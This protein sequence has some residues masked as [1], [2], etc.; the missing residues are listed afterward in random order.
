[1]LSSGAVVFYNRCN[2][3]LANSI[4]SAT[5]GDTYDWFSVDLSGFGRNPVPL[6]TRPDL[7]DT[8]TNADAEDCLDGT[9]STITLATAGAPY[10][11]DVDQDGTSESYEAQLNAD[12]QTNEVIWSAAAKYFFRKGAT[13]T[14]DGVQ[15]Q[16]FRFLDAAYTVTK[17]SPIGT[18]AGGTIFYARGWVPVD[19]DVV[20]AS[21]YQ[22]VTSDGVPKKPPTFRL[23]A[24]TGLSSG[25]KVLLTR[26]SSPGFALTAEFTL[27]SGNDSGDGTLVIAE[28]IPADKPP[29]GFVRVFD[30]TGQEDR[31]AYSSWSGSTF[32]LTGTLSKTYA[33]GNDSYVPYIDE[34]ASSA[35]ISKSLRYVSDRDVVLFV[36][37]G[38]GAGK[39][40]PFV[41]NF[42]L[43]DSDSSVPA[44]V[45]ADSINSN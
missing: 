29:S 30:N 16:L 2:R 21:T 42:T 23:R 9:T 40:I 35:S 14:F 10:S 39:M 7:D 12:G 41:S 33:A 31:Y 20:D 1:M 18:I 26:R 27:A 38:S 22:V 19:V 15:A 5:N 28:S 25:Q 43:G 45:I 36:R 4:D 24:V 34:T 32:T 13:T 44:T 37:L 6:N 8:L 11:V 17:D 3:D